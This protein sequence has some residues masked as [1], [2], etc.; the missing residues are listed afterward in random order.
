MQ[1]LRRYLTHHQLWDDDQETELL[2]ALDARVA[3]AVEEYKALPPEPATAMFDHLYAELPLA[4]LEQR[5][6]LERRHVP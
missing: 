1:R 4:L 6:E 3:A 2:A 5:Q